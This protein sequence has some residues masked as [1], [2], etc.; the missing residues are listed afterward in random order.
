MSSARWP[1]FALLLS[2][3]ACGATTIPKGDDCVYTPVRQRVVFAEGHTGPVAL[4]SDLPSGTVV[5][6]TDL[7]C[8]NT[9]SDNRTR[10]FT[11]KKGDTPILLIVGEPEVTLQYPFTTPFRESNTDLTLDFEVGGSAECLLLGTTVEAPD[12]CGV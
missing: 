4:F 5:D 7:I 8:T 12:D 3:A 9:S 6:V 11:V 1:I 2:G 10:D